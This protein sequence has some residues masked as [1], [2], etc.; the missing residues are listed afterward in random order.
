MTQSTSVKVPFIAANVTKCMCPRCPVQAG[1][2]CA[3]GKMGTIKE[4]LKASPLK[5]E[6]IPGVYCAS[7]TATCKDIDTKQS[8]LCGACMVFGQYKLANSNPVGHYC[9]DGASR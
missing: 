3:S 5:K 2:S 8:C 1:S 7:G 4:A 6:D 9:R